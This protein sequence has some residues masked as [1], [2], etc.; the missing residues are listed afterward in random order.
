MLTLSHFRVQFATLV[1]V[2]PK[3]QKN[4]PANT[5]HLNVTLKIKFYYYY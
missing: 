1:L 4:V 3:S 2:K 5:C